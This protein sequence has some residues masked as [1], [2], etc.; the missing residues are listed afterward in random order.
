[1]MDVKVILIWEILR[2]LILIN[3]RIIVISIS[4][5]RN[6]MAIRKKCIENGIRA[7]DLGS[8]PHSKGDIFSRSLIF[9]FE[10]RLDRSIIII[11]INITISIVSG[12]IHTGFRS[13]DWKSIIIFILYKYLPHQ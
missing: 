3:G 5:I 8:K 2:I 12:I 9:F 7:D 13:F 4:K 11:D 10:R 6:R 1:M